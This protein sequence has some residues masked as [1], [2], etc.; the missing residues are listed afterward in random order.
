MSCSS[1]SE[2]NDSCAR[3]RS[4]VRWT[5]R[6]PPLGRLRETRTHFLSIADAYRVFRPSI[7]GHRLI[8]RSV[9]LP[10]SFSRYF[11]F[12]F[13]FFFHLSFST[14]TYTQHAQTHTHARTHTPLHPLR[15]FS[16]PFRFAF[17]TRSLFDSHR[18]TETRTIRILD[19]TFSLGEN[20]RSIPLNK[21]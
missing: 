10:T 18:F 17:L 11:F 1:K 2:D 16:T 20:T 7:I 6:F 3:A 9:P 12:F 19:S 13:F 4:S 5:E 15:T 8:G 14:R 21:K